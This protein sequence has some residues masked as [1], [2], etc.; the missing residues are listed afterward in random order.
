MAM[1]GVPY[2]DA[3]NR[4]PALAREQAA[5][6]AAAIVSQGG[7]SGLERKE[8]VAIIAY[9]QRLGKDIQVA[10]NQTVTRGAPAA[11]GRP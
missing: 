4:A 11:G 1:L 9:L 2:G 3:V 7:P 10:P 5:R 6:V 8:V